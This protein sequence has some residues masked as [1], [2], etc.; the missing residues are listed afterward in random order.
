M[1]NIQMTSNSAQINK[2]LAALAQRQIPFAASRALNQTGKELLGINKRLM[3]RQFDNPVPYTINAFRLVRSTKQNL[4]AEVRRKDAGSG[5]NKPASSRNY[6][7]R[8]Q[9]GGTRRN[10][11]IENKFKGKVAELKSMQ[12]LLPTSRTSV[13]GQNIS[14]AKAEKVLAGLQSKSGEYPRY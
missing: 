6:L 14:V 11:G 13:R 7:E 8:Q 4:V 2:K 12:A 10:K 1:F 5:N 3:Q 9:S